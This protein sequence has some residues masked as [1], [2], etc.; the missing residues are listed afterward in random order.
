MYIHMYVSQ[1]QKYHADA[2]DAMKWCCIVVIAAIDSLYTG[3]E[4]ETWW[5]TQLYEWMNEYTILILIDINMNA[6]QITKF[7]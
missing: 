6:K 4:D 5:C 2:K 1:H 7:N 3:T